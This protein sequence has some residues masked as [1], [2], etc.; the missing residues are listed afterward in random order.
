MAVVT[1]KKVLNNVTGGVNTYLKTDLAFR[2]LAT[3]T[4]LSFTTDT[5]V[6]NQVNSLP[7]NTTIR[8]FDTFQIS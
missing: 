6:K 4:N 3:G 5:G 2:A 7:V 8:Q 1:K